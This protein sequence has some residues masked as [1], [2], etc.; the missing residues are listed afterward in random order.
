MSSAL[1]ARDGDRV[2]HS[3]DVQVQWDWLGPLLPYFPFFLIVVGHVLGVYL[4]AR[5]T[6]LQ[7]VHY[8]GLYSDAMASVS[9]LTFCALFL[10][11]LGRLLW[12]EKEAQP[13][14]RIVGDVRRYVLNGRNVLARGRSHRAAC[15]PGRRKRDPTEMD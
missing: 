1:R 2:V 15:D 13:T 3:A 4:L 14:R 6:G 11:Y 12:I 10:L 8:F 9:A 7:D 5:A